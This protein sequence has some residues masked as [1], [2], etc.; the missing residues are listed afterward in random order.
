MRVYDLDDYF[1]FDVESEQVN[2]TASPL[3]IHQYRYGGFATR[4]AREWFERPGS[5]FL[6][7]EGKGRE[8]GNYTRP[9]WVENFR[10]DR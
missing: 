5:G 7:S 8:E 1:W 2:V 3:T 4:G 10:V 6:T 9:A